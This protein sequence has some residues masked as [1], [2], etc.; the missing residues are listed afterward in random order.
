MSRRFQFSL[1]RFFLTVAFITLLGSHVYTS[2]KLKQ[3]RED[4]ERMATELGRLTI[5]DASRLNVLALG[6]YDEM[7]WRWRIHVPI[8]R[9]YA[10]YSGT[11][12]IPLT[13][14]PPEH[15]GVQTVLRPGEYVLTA[16]VRHDSLDRWRLTIADADSSMRATIQ[17]P[18]AVWLV[19][20]HDYTCEQAGAHSTQAT[21]DEPLV[22][23]R[24]NCEAPG[25]PGT[26]IK[27]A[28]IMIWAAERGLDAPE[29]ASTESDAVPP[30][31]YPSAA[32]PHPA[33]TESDSPPLLLD[34]PTT[35]PEPIE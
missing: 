17:E 22:F 4:A 29:A 28:G 23:L 20:S 9:E 14:V 11:R 27:T 24:L 10:I 21:G 1:S 26:D 25:T 33:S 12:E 6:T 19:D 18:D 34:P 2:W 30:L 5:K 16:A 13:G 15:G 31:L 32:T 8:T 35:T 3:S 7:T